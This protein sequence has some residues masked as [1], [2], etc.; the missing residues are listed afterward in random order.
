VRSLASNRL[1]SQRVV[2]LAAFDV[3]FEHD[4][5]QRGVRPDQ[6]EKTKPRPKNVAPPKE[7]RAGPRAADLRATATGGVDKLDRPA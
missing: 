6:L 4:T 2:Q 5:A 3:P 7:D 1:L